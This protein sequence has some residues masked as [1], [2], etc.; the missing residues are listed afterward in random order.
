MYTLENSLNDNVDE[1]NGESHEERQ[2][3]YEKAS[4]KPI[5]TQLYI[6][7]INIEIFV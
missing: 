5:V 1:N 7:A 6:I 2:T 4:F 3:I